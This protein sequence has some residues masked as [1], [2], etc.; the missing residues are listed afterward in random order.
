MNTKEK[1]LWHSVVSSSNLASDATIAKDQTKRTRKPTMVLHSKPPVRAYVASGISIF[2]AGLLAIGCMAGDGAEDEQ[3]GNTLESDVETIGS[4]EEA[5]SGPTCLA[6][7]AGKYCGNDNI[8]GGSANTLYHCP[9]G[10]GA[11]ASVY[12]V[13]SSGCYVA[14]P[15]KN[16]YCISSCTTTTNCNNC[17]S[18]AR[19]RKPSLPTGL[20]YYSQKKAIINSYTPSA[21]AVA[22]INT[23]DAY[24]HVA[25][26]ESVNGSTITI[27]EGNWPYGSCGQ[28]SNTASALKIVGYY[29]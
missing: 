8:S 23:G 2:T 4:T 19:C 12:Q 16:D 29:K 10:V 24:G 1:H 9:G 26:V 7:A 27:S 3:D 25:Y 6:S 14:P 13:C 20:T 11:S 17:V 18:Y 5:L 15:G 28:R 21:G 22:I